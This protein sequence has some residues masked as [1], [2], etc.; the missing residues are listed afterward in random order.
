MLSV[1]RRGRAR[2]RTHRS[3]QCGRRIEHAAHMLH[4]CGRAPRARGH[5]IRV[6]SARHTHCN[7]KPTHTLCV[8]RARDYYYYHHR[9]HHRHHYYD[10]DYDYD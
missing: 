1:C 7:N 10:Y 9:R 2:V 5:T 4:H 3:A 8:L 6:C